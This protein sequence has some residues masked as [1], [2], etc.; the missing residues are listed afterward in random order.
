MKQ[1]DF[2]FAALIMELRDGSYDQFYSLKIPSNVLLYLIFCQRKRD[3]NHS[4]IL[5][6]DA[7]LMFT[8]LS[9]K[10]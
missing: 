10:E 3:C 2:P 9:E 4:I 6:S 8:F 7:L 1:S 5:P